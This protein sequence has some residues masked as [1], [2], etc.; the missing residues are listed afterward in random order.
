MT[1]IV[2]QALDN[3]IFATIGWAVAAT[4]GALWV[5][6]SWWTYRD[7]TWRTGSTFLGALASAWIVLST[8]LLLPLSVGVYVLA[9]PQHTAAEGRSRRLIAELVAQL[10]GEGAAVCPSCATEVEVDWLRCPACATWLAVPCAH[11]GGWAE[12]GLEI[13][14]WCGSEERDAP[15]VEVLKP[16]AATAPRKQR[17]RHNR[18]QATD[19]MPLETRQPRSR[20]DALLDPR[21]PVRVASR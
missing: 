9:R 20:I 8:P 17:R 11:C 12:E 14:P 15:S 4:V 2:A 21:A 16:A 5:A 3:P 1:D 19:P 13:C 6:A 10:D 7:A 18:R